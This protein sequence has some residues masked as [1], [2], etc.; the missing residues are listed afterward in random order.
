MYTDE[1]ECKRARREH[2]A[3]W[4]APAAAAAVGGA[5]PVADMLTQAG[6]Q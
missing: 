2:C 4:V 3:L 6:W 5:S 1:R